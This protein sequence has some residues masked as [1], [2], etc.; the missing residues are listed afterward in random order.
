[1]TEKTKTPRPED[2]K[3]TAKSPT[4]EELNELKAAWLR[5]AESNGMIDELFLIVKTFG[6]IPEKRAFPGHDSL[7]RFE[8]TDGDSDYVILLNRSIWDVGG[9]R[10]KR[11]G[12]TLEEWERIF[13][14]QD[15]EY[16]K[17]R[18][19]R[20]KLVRY[21]RHLNLAPNGEMTYDH[22]EKLNLNIFVP[23]YWEGLIGVFAKDARYQITDGKK[24]KVDKERKNLLNDLFHGQEA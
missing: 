7:R 8:F 12:D 10:G 18:V 16:L 4:V 3:I 11:P 5:E 6:V 1:M 24:G 15:G 9:M 14:V 2:I 20:K 22:Q 21:Y 23:G 17:E 13:V 19:S